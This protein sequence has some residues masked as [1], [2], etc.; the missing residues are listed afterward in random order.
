M[1][2]SKYRLLYFIPP[3]LRKHVEFVKGLPR[4]IADT[5]TNPNTYATLN[6]VL[7]PVEWVIAPV[8]NTRK[9]I[10]SGYKDMG[11]LTNA[12]IETLG[13]AAGPIAHKYASTL[14]PVASKGVSSGVKSLQELVMPLG[15]SDDVAEEISKKTGVNRRQFI[16]GTAALGAASGLKG[17]GDIFPTSKVIKAT[18]KSPIFSTV[19][20][21]NLLKGKFKAKA[22]RY[23]DILQTSKD[24]EFN[25]E[26]GSLPSTMKKYDNDLVKFEEDALAKREE[27]MD[28]VNAIEAELMEL[29]DNIVAE[30]IE[31]VSKLSEGQL[32]NLRNT[33]TDEYNIYTRVGDFDH[34]ISAPENLEAEKIINKA[35]ENKGLMN[36]DDFRKSKRTVKNRKEAGELGIAGD[37]E[38]DFY[39]NLTDDKLSVVDEFHSSL[40]KDYNKGGLTTDE[41][42]QKEFNKG[43]T[44]MEQQMSLFEEGG[45]KDDGLDR[46]PVSGNEIPPGSLAKEVRDDIPAQLSDGE[47]VVP[48]DVVQYYGVK[49][50]ED[51]RREAKRGLAQMEATGRIGGEPV[52][53]DMTMIAF[54]KPDKNKKEKKFKGG[55]IGYTNGGVA[56]EVSQVEKARTFSGPSYGVLG[57]TPDS[58]IYQTA[59]GQPQQEKTTITYYHSQTGESK[60][61]TFINGVVTPSSDLEFTQPPWS[62]NKPTIKTQVS[63]K[64]DDRDRKDSP[65]GW[66]ADPEKYDF[67]GWGKEDWE[68]EVNS[69]LNPTGVLGSTLGQNAF[70][71]AAS[72]ANSFAAIELAKAKNV[73]TSKMEE[74]AQKA[75][76]GLGVMGK[77]IV[78]GTNKLL[79]VGGEGAYA[80]TVARTNPTYANLGIEDPTSTNIKDDN[81]KSNGNNKPPLTE[82]EEASRDFYDDE[83]RGASTITGKTYVN[84]DGGTSRTEDFGKGRVTTVKTKSDT[85]TAA[86][87]KFDKAITTEDYGV[88]LAEANKEFS[89]K[90]ETTSDDDYYVG[91]KGGLATKTKSKPKTRKPRGKGLGIK[92]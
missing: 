50:F 60:V 69:L 82:S 21:L 6:Q 79:M 37:Y 15:A 91:N 92:K 42:T 34:R 61:V 45:M 5:V 35:L 11:A 27:L 46:D 7:N 53:V 68:R 85:N 77:I 14:S 66:G 87:E 43:G 17:V 4:I 76:D 38:Y 10:D 80:E 16:A 44:T 81:N 58:P 67:T 71:R 73:D 3:E 20:D 40:K 12:T 18:A 32:V 72:V 19:V 64:D 1:D 84:P 90:T 26:I 13:L 39:G 86:K 62:I 52:A 9:F 57:F 33:F 36:L 89:S 70:F 63:K 74:A 24:I 29:T 49:F 83:R 22:L 28:V 23:D 75:Y 54:G 51:L 78:T 30:G 56:D 59:Q 31:G 25:E 55:V 88:S 8:R 65:P 47:Y 2:K 48:A 41:Q